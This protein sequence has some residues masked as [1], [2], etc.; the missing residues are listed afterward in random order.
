MGDAVLSLAIT[1]ALMRELPKA[2]EGEMTKIR[3][4]LV[5]GQSLAEAALDLGFDSLLKTARKKDRSNPRLLAGAF[6]A[7]LGAVYLDSGY[8]A[9]EKIILS[10]FRKKIKKKFF[11]SDYKSS[12]QEWSQRTYR[13][14]PEYRL[15][16]EEG[17]S[18][19]RLF[20]VDALVDSQVLGSGSDRQKKQAEQ[21][22]A[23]EA[24]KN[25]KVPL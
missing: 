13:Q 3:G 12:L 1:D 4:S 25:L 5:S 24:L 21:N 22:A 7:F 23:R 6:E 18:H 14:I 17:P 9:A 2:T 15:K 11:Y 10:L 16:K 8:P 19:K 20:Y